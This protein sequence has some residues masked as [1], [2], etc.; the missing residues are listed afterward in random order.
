M[1]EKEHYEPTPEETSNAEERMTNEEKG[2]SETRES[3]KKEYH[4]DFI[5]NKMFSEDLFSEEEADESL[6]E[7]WEE[8]KKYLEQNLRDED[9]ETALGLL[10]KSY[11]TYK[12]APSSAK[13][14]SNMPYLRWLSGNFPGIVPDGLFDAY[15]DGYISKYA[16]ISYSLWNMSDK[17]YA[18]LKLMSLVKGEKMQPEISELPFNIRQRE[19]PGYYHGFPVGSIES[20]LADGLKSNRSLSAEK[21]R[22]AESAFPF[23][24][25]LSR[26]DPDSKEGGNNYDW[27]AN[28]YRETSVVTNSWG[29][30]GRQDKS[31]PHLTTNKLT[32][33]IDY[34]YI[35]PRSYVTEKVYYGNFETNLDEE[36][37]VVDVIPSDKIVGI[38]CNYRVVDESQDSR[39]EYVITDE[40]EIPVEYR[41][42]D[43][44]KSP[45]SSLPDEVR[46]YYRRRGNYENTP[47]MVKQRDMVIEAVKRSGR[48]IKVYSVDGSLLW[49]KEEICWKVAKRF[50]EEVLSKLRE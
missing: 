47:E 48:D 39:M 41:D 44:S 6:V 22:G 45:G 43:I 20:V 19:L 2:L 5:K 11:L 28:A 12:I 8:L 14:V 3:E 1:P 37:S 46:E 32:A 13:E 24:V 36:Q 49:P 9:R 4:V 21:R 40:S 50:D 26:P 30:D 38:I 35:L 16:R 29:A 7:G 27:S 34:D 17:R 33:I 10:A 15:R 42:W 23:S 25:S 31:R 18:K